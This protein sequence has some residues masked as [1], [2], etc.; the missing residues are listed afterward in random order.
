MIELAYTST[1][2][3]RY[4]EDDL[5]DIL[6]T[7]REN[8]AKAGITGILLHRGT[9]VLQLLEGEAGAVRGLYAKLLQDRRHHG[10]VLLHDREIV[11][12][13]F[14][15]WS[16]AFEPLTDETSC[17]EGVHRLVGPSIVPNISVAQERRRLVDL[18]VKTVR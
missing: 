1:T 2:A 5:N 11:A 9:T 15:Q 13:A 16:M 12:R 17:P 7:S 18:F 14:G 6:K 3:W 10:L 4:T 8:N